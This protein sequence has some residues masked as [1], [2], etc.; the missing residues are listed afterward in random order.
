MI[1][2]IC[3]RFKEGNFRDPTGAVPTQS[4][5]EFEIEIP[6]TFQLKSVFLVL[7]NDETNHYQYLKMIWDGIIRGK[8]V[9]TTTIN[10]NQQGLNWYYFQLETISDT[11]YVGKKGKS[12]LVLDEEPPSWQLTVY[13][14][15]FNTPDWIKGGLIYHIFVDRFARVGYPP[16]KENVI[17]RNDWGGMPVYLP[18]EEGEILNNDFFGGN[19]KGIIEKLDYLKELGV[20]CIYLSPIFEAYSNHK[21]DTGDF[22]KI[23]S[24]FGSIEDFRK[25]CKE[26]KNRGMRILL[27]GVF[28]HTGSNSVYFNKNGSYNSIGAYQSKESPYY[29]W[30]TFLEYPDKYVSWWGIK[31]LPAVKENEPSFLDFITGGEGIAKKWLKEGASGWRLDVLDELPDRFIDSFR[32]AVKS[33]DAD[34][35]LIGEVWEDASYKMSYGHRRRYLLGQQMDS[36][37]NYPF[38]NA[39]IRFV[40]YGDAENLD[41]VV[42]SILQNYPLCVVHCLMNM[43]GTHDTKRIL[44]AL[45][46]KELDGTTREV[47]A[48][49]VMSQEERQMA[50]ELLKMA[51]LIQMT[52]PGVPCIYYG[53][54]VGLEGYEDPFN[55]RCFPWGKEHTEL[56]KWYQ[57][58]GVLRKEWD[59]FKE[60]SYETIFANEHV[61]IFQRKNDFE[62]VIVGV[63][64]SKKP[65]PL[66]LGSLYIDLLKGTY[67]GENFVLPPDEIC[68]FGLK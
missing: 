31:T 13:D 58:L 33:H 10:V 65:F 44:T 12:I 51:S 2:Q 42:T 47:Q 56:L 55:R 54:E 66:E 5:I 68:I 9:Y 32:K 1:E 57:K 18:N 30:Y 14:H 64:R 8:D 22:T 16:T 45:G 20:T 24:M 67:V 11:F 3:S 50:I 37:M 15:Q 17:L 49:T 63:N 21:Y 23:D 39:I 26:S 62:K 61:Y 59:V 60:G 19:L 7:I 43:L 40:K 25:L 4:A 27:D 28:N 36:I 34:T 6:R 48:S 46:G 53:D 35:L 52:L 41:E 38:M 29:S